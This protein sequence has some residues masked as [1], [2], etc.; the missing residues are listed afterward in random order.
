MCSIPRNMV[1]D[2]WRGEG[3]N[4]CDGSGWGGRERLMVPCSAVDCDL[5][6]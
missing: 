1:E 3:F 4:G 6:G 2:R 5:D